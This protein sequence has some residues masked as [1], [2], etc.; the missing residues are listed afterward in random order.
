MLRSGRLELG[1]EDKVDFETG[2][3]G[4][5]LGADLYFPTETTPLPAHLVAAADPAVLARSPHGGRV[6]CGRALEARAD[7]TADLAAVGAG[8]SFCVTTTEGN[9]VS[10]TI[11][12]C[13]P[14]AP[15][16]LVLDFTTWRP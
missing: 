2:T 5:V 7:R 3:A 10:A 11:V 6:A 16:R 15:Q 12:L 9:V 14:S 8:R 13:R 1:P 4:A